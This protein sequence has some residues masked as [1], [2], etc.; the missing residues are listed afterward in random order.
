M[1]KFILA[2]FI[3]SLFACQTNGGR[4]GDIGPFQVSGFEVSLGY[5]YT[6]CQNSNNNWSGS[7]SPEHGQF[8]DATFSGSNSNGFCPESKVGT[9]VKFIWSLK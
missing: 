2:I 7:L 6:D 8:G 9:E 3:A 4:F 1:H 5:D